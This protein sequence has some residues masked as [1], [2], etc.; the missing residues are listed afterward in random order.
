MA[1][2]ATRRRSIRPKWE[3]VFV[4][5]PAYVREKARRMRVERDFTIDEIAE[6]LAISRQTIYHWVRKRR[7]GGSGDRSSA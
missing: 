4:T 5:Y 3:H 6:R 2:E 1:G 7:S